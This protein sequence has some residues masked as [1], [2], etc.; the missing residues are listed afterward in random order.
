V[1][2]HQVA[3]VEAAVV[4]GIERRLTFEQQVAA[5]R[6]AHKLAGS[7]GTFGFT[8]GSRLARTLE[9]ALA[10][11]EVI[12]ALDALELSR[13]VMEL[14]A[15]MARPVD[16][17]A[18]RESPGQAPQSVL[19]VDGSAD[20]PR[21][22]VE[23]AA[24]Q[25]VR[26]SVATSLA[27]ARESIEAAPPGVVVLDAGMGTEAE[28][29]AFR[30]GLAG[31]PSTIATVLL[32]DTAG[33]DERVQAARGGARTV[34]ELPAPPDRIVG[35]V[36][37][38]LGRQRASTTV[39]AVDDDPLFLDIIGE[40]LRAEGID[41]QTL[42]ATETLLDKLAEIQPDLLLLDNQMPGVDG[43][44]LCRAIRSDERWARLPIV[45]LSGSRSPDVVREMF[46]AGADDFVAKPVAPNDLV[47]RVMSRIER[48]RAQGE[49]ANVDLA[50]GLPSARAFV[51][52][53]GRL[54]ALGHQYGRTVVLA[55][56]ELDPRADNA[57]VGFGRILLQAAEAGD[58]VGAWSGGRLAAL[59]YDV[60]PAGAEARL[61]QLLAAARVLPG[62]AP[63]RVSVGMAVFP[64]DGADIRVLGA[65]AEVALGEARQADA[66]AVVRYESPAKGRSEVVDVLLVDDDEAL[67]TL[68]VHALST[69]G[70]TVRWLKDGAEAVDLLDEAGFRAR[71]VLLD[72]GLPG[73][74][75]LS[76]L[77]HMNRNGLLR[78]TQV[79]MLT[80]RANEG[81][82]LEALD[83]GAFDHVAKPFSLPVLMHRVRRAVDA[84][85]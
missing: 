54:L 73:L 48:V 56:A 7:L 80:V 71:A 1:L 52:D 8:A 36:T 43:L 20:R 34:L 25:G 35:A 47:T 55:V 33:L 77:R 37:R 21:R 51:K 9:L 62:P 79:V 70:W 45:F 16:P 75:G 28:V 17:P 57:F 65:A 11:P 78:R 18:P 69:R 82:V 22:V 60:T 13:A 66:D 72:V 49:R 29:D 67:G 61:G 41:V 26:A 63:A 3:V 31:H 15:D 50:T 38:L 19:I 83:L 14:Q 6:E 4:A 74:D 84:G 46:A 30:A 23:A 64:D 85:T 58:A 12:G 2:R 59:L 10:S 24:A 39:L 42:E 27:G 53:A 5:G 40:F 44:S 76:V 68:V 81:E 32:V